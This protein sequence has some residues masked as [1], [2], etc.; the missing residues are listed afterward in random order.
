MEGKK[1][2]VLHFPVEHK[3]R[4]EREH[5]DYSLPELLQMTREKIEELNA[6]S[7]SLESAA[8]NGNRVAIY[9]KKEGLLDE[10]ELFSYD[11]DMDYERSDITRA[12]LVSH[13]YRIER[14][15]N[16]IG[17]EI[18]KHTGQRTDQEK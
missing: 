13:L 1:A 18:T 6:A 15:L 12:Q 17:K 14:V 5:A 7:F 11:T 8:K 10:I 16:V 4:F 9:L 3:E 2:K